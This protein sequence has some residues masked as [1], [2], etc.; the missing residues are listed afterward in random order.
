MVGYVKKMIV[1]Y[2]IVKNSISK[3]SCF[4]PEDS[5]AIFSKYNMICVNTESKGRFNDLE[6]LK[7]EILKIYT[8]V[9]SA[10]LGV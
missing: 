2:T 10:S 3:F 4:L 6:S 9:G 8:D 7:A 5:A 1:F